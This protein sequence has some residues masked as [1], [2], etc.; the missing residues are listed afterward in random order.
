MNNQE[1]LHE[2]ELH[3]QGAVE[4]VRKHGHAITYFRVMAI[5]LRRHSPPEQRRK[6]CLI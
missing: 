2:V 1:M 4:M 6:V 5:S 3:Y